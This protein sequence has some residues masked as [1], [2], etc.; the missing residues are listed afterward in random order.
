[1]YLINHLTLQSIQTLFIQAQRYRSSQALVGLKDGLNV[2]FH[3]PGYEKYLQNL[4][5]FSIHVYLNGQRLVLLDDYIVVESGG[6]GTGF[7]TVILSVAPRP[8]DKVIS[9]YI[10][11]Y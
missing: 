9:D 6:V 3:T 8:R 4:P 11:A 2:V 10:L 1:V 7:D 5:Y